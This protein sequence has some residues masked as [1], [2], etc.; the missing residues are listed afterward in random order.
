[1]KFL[2]R[3]TVLAVL[4][5]AAALF[6]SVRTYSV[7]ARE[8]QIAT[9]RCV[10]RRANGSYLL[11]LIPM[12]DGVSG[13]GKVYI[14]NGDQW[15]VG[16]DLLKWRPWVSVLGARPLYKL[17]RLESRYL[18]AGDEMNKPRTVIELNGGSSRL[19]RW[20]HQRG[21]RL[22]FVDA[23]YGNAAFVS[24]QPD[25]EWGIY[26]SDSGFWIKPLRRKR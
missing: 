17:T 2:F 24:V 15:V 10:E 11:E 16:G 26:L 21:I 18:K 4:A 22:P 25:K 20:L 3:M 5:A 23:L 14:L 7:L 13:A 19:W 12:H 9:V 8:Q 6:W 1:M